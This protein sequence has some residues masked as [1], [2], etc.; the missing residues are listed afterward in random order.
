M[1]QGNAMVCVEEKQT[2]HVDLGRKE[3]AGLLGLNGPMII[4]RLKP[5]ILII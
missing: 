4:I 1:V 3:E 2:E 5:N